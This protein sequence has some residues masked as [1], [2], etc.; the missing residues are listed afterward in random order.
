MSQENV[1]VVERLYEIWSQEEFPGGI[2]L[3]D[4]DIEYVN[5]EGAIEPGVRK[6]IA[7]FSGAVE[8]LR[9]GWASWEMHPER[10]VSVAD[11]VAVVI[12]YAARA[13][14]SDI[15]LNGRESALLTVRHG[16]VVRYEWF[17]GPDDA[18]KAVGL[19]E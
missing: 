1:E 16:K 17:H 2:D 18:L 12:R 9:E 13:R 5:P 15:A 6:G 11:K 19:A 4:P 3:L 14:S 8:K 7:E 10:F